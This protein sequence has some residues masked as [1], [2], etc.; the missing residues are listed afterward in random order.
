MFKRKGAI[1][2]VERS[3]PEPGQF[4]DPV[5][6]LT[7]RPMGRQVAVLLVRNCATPP[8]KLE[9][10]ALL[11]ALSTPGVDAPMPD[12]DFGEFCHYCNH[13]VGVGGERSY[14]ASS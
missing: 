12:D 7:Y 5:A 10:L 3:S 6:S 9:D 4:P 11:F 1:M 13:R 2:E 8:S 14:Y